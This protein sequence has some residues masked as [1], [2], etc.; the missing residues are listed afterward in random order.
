MYPKVDLNLSKTWV[1]S[2]TE[3]NARFSQDDEFFL[4]HLVRGAKDPHPE[5][6]ERVKRALEHEKKLNERIQKNTENFDSAIR[7]GIPDGVSMTSMTP[8]DA[9]RID[10]VVARTVIGLHLHFL[11][12]L[13]SRDKQLRIGFFDESKVKDLEQ[14]PAILGKAPTLDVVDGSVCRIRAYT[15]DGSDEDMFWFLEFYNSKVFVV[16]AM[17]PELAKK[18]G[19]LNKTYVDL[20]IP[21]GH[22][23]NYS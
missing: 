7:P 4:I 11:G 12:K 19:E 8:R 14:L 23:I 1:P 18:E 15:I 10:N 13:M 21:N 3:C 16:Q 6:A 5:I 22:W 2:C 17:S 20:K 9:Q